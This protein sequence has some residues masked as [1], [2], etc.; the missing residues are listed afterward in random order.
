[1]ATRS[2]SLLQKDTKYG[3]WKVKRPLRPTQYYFGTETR[4]YRELGKRWYADALERQGADPVRLHEYEGR[5]WWW[6]KK[7]V[8]VERER[9]AA[10]DV[11]AL[12]LKLEGEKSATLERAHAEMRGEVAATSAR[13]REPISEAVRH[14]V[15]RRDQG[16]C[17]DCG[18]KSALEFD[19]IIP[20]SQG[21]SNTVRN[22]ELRCE[23]CNRKKGAQT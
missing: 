16:Q 2:R 5:T 21:G 10:E 4:P 20:W 23:I 3:V 9:L 22:L 7:Q 11:K 6:F 18:S 13:P 12:A 15:W 19:H 1:V 14:E 17:V 8:Y